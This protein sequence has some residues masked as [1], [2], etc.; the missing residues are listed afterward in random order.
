MALYN[1]WKDISG[2]MENV[3]C[4]FRRSG[5]VSSKPHSAL[6]VQSN[7]LATTL[8]C[9]QELKTRHLKYGLGI[10]LLQ[11]I[12]IIIRLMI[13]VQIDKQTDLLTL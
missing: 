5:P 11:E 10:D 3:L 1:L 7:S 9:L 2:T 13:L 4:V 6:L 12:S 8:A